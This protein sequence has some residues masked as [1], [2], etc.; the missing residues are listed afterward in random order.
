[1]KKTFVLKLVVFFV[2][3]N[4]FI[5]MYGC[6]DLDETINAGNINNEKDSNEILVWHFDKNEGPEIVKEFKK[7][8]KDIEV[9]LKLVSMENSAYQSKI[10]TLIN[11]KGLVPDVYPAEATFLKSFVELSNGYDDLSKEPYCAD[12]YIGNMYNYLID[13]GRDKDGILRVLSH[14]STPVGIGYKRDLAHEYLGTD[15]PEELSKRFSSIDEIIKLGEELKE[16]SDGEIKLFTGKD[17]LIRLYLGARVEPWIKDDKFIIDPLLY[18]FM[19]VMKQI[20][21]EELDSGY[22][23]W[24]EEWKDSFKDKTHFAYAIPSWGVLYL[25]ELYEDTSIIETGRWGICKPPYHT[26]WGGTWFGIYSESENKNAAWEFLKFL[27]I[28][29]DFMLMRT[30]ETKD[31]PNNKKVAKEL[32]NDINFMSKTISENLFKSF[33]TLSENINGN[34]LTIY[35]DIINKEFSESVDW[36]INNDVEKKEAVD[37]FIDNIEKQLSAKGISFEDY[38]DEEESGE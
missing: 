36:Y 11:S 29:N 19:G 30:K 9:H 25:I 24:E 14:K 35:D 33:D 22:K 38:K 27:T 13:M 32:S 26:Y 12:K 28:D 17:E 7:R 6:G 4:A 37:R 23:I 8:N 16:K 21:K 31:F 10:T 5:I 15:D 20:R 1:M 34:L 3:V 18:D 2:Y